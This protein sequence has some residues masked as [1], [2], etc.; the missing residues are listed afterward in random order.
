MV[1]FIVGAAMPRSTVSPLCLT[2]GQL[3]K[4]WSVSIARIRQLID[5]GLLPGAFRIPSAGRYGETLK[6]PLDT[7]TAVERLWAATPV[8]P[9]LQVSPR[10]SLPRRELTHFPELT[11]ASE[12][13][14]E[15]R[16]VEPR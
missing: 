6:I 1:R 9:R 15:C 16:A 8:Q 7:I 5:N 3:A 14:A 10:R 2:V 12:S 11:S 13:D 4:R